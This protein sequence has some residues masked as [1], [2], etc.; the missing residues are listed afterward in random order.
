AMVWWAR[1]ARRGAATSYA[2]LAP[3]AALLGVALLLSA[4]GLAGGASRA[5]PVV[6]VN[7]LGGLTMLALCA[8]LSR[9][10]AR[11]GLGRAA[12]VMVGLVLLQACAGA[13]AATQAS[14]DCASFLGCAP[15]AWVHRLA[16]V[17]LA[18]GL[19]MFGLWAAWRQGRRAGSVVALLGVALLLLGALAAALGGAAPP[20]LVVLHNTAGALA[21]ALLVRE[22]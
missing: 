20:W 17:L 16:G 2:P 4:V 13:L 7:L 5:A 12:W 6:L 22:A 10:P 18:F 14:A 3:S 9:D 21:L 11:T 19:A 8:R 15:A 1:K